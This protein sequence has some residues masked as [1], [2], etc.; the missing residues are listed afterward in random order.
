MKTI[1]KFPI[2][3]RLTK[4]DGHISKPLCVQTQNDKMMLWVE[5]DTTAPNAVL[6]VSYKGT[7]EPFDDSI[8][9]YLSTVQR[10]GY[11]WH[12]YYRMEVVQ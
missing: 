1:Y 11:V 4:I 6:Y 8:G 2:T 9:I 5:M 12:F 10:L 3:P 7:G